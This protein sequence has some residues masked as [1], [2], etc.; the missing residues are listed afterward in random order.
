MEEGV[1][2]N[3]F[4]KRD[5]AAFTT[6][7]D[8]LFLEVFFY[9]NSLFKDTNIDPTDVAQ[10]AFVDIYERDG[11]VFQNRKQLKSY[12][13]VMIRNRYKVHYNHLKVRENVHDTLAK[14]ERLFTNE[15]AEAEIFSIMSY[16]LGLLPEEC[17]RVMRLYLA[18]YSIKEIAEITG[19][20]EFTVYKQRQQAINILKKR[21]PKDKLLIFLAAIM[22][23]SIEM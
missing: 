19:K 8:E 1:L 5:A 14:S 15:A 21:L 3:L 6:L 10:D 12:I 20:S 11:V 23:Q 18:D 16:G 2:F 17:A 22:K 4:N 13:Y 7:Y 9:A